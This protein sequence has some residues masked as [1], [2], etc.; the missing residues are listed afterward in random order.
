MSLFNGWDLTVSLREIDD[1]HHLP[2]ILCIKTDDVIYND[3]QI[4]MK[5]TYFI[6]VTDS[7]L[8]DAMR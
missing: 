3:S 4:N 8:I 1:L 5:Y 6:L 7:S 2:S